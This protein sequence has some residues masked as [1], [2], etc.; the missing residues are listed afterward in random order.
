MNESDRI[1]AETRKLL[2]EHLDA[3]ADPGDDALLARV[4][5]KVL[6]AI[7]ARAGASGTT[8]RES[9]GEWRPVAPGVTRKLLRAADHA[10]SY[11]IRMEPG[12]RVDG[13]FHPMDEECVVLEGCL[14]IEPDIV[15]RVGDF[16]VGHKATK[17]GTAWTDTGALLF[18]RGAAQG[19][20]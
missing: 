2:D 18:V 12:S 4:K 14:H 16:H 13:H 20:A 19:V 9:D 1:D 11:M 15:L 10:E 3:C 7:A 5:L 8:V 6:A 17:H